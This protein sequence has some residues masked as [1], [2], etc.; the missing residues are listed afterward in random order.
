M[1][2]PGVVDFRRQLVADL[3]DGYSVLCLMND[4]DPVGLQRQLLDDIHNSGRDYRIVDLTLDAQPDDWPVDVLSRQL[5]LPP[6]RSP[7]YNLQRFLLEMPLPEII[8]ITGLDEAGGTRQRWLRFFADWSQAAHGITS[9]GGPQPGRLF[10]LLCPADGEELPPN[11]TR[12]RRRWWWSLPSALEMAL[13]CRLRATQA[14]DDIGPRVLWREAI[15]PTIAGNDPAMLDFL[16]DEV[17]QDFDHLLNRL[18]HYAALCGWTA[19]ALRR[20]G[21]EE[22]ARRRV[23]PATPDRLDAV[24]R[25]LWGTGVLGYTPEYGP[26]LSSAALVV[27]GDVE[28]VRHRL[29]HGQAS[30]TLP[31]LDQFRLD[32]CRQLAGGASAAYED[33]NFM[34]WSELIDTLKEQPAPRPSELLERVYEARRVRN[35]LAHYKLITFQDYS[36]F[37]GTTAYP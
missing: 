37:T 34:D 10:A 18:G 32:A 5:S 6:A 29:W 11:E 13:L 33:H 9:S 26:M 28:A 16:W 30:L 20:W 35:K 4:G 19:Q 27:L 15:L 23:R 3:A 31:L 8:I 1:R 25:Q 21:C 17:Y 12:L 24:G 7:T 22:F 14:G 2:A 36:K